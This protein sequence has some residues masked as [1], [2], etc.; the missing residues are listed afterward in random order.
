PQ[1]APTAIIN[2]TIHTVA[3]GTI[4]R[5]YVLF[6][7][8]KIIEVKEG[9]GAFTGITRLID[10]D[11]Q[12][13]YPGL[14][15]AMTQ[16][17]LDEISAVRAMRDHNEVGRLSPEVHAAI[18]VNPDSTL[19]PVAR[20]N[21]ILIAGSWPTGGLVPGRASVLQLEGWTTE[22]MALDPHAGVIINWPLARP[23]VEWWMDQTESDQ[24][25]RINANRARID[26][27]FQSAITY[28]AQDPAARTPDLRLDAL[29]DTLPTAN[30]QKPVFISAQDMDQITTA[31]EW[32]IGLDLK[33]VIV[34]GRDAPMV[35]EL[36]K[37]HDVPVILRGAHGFPKRADSNYDD[38][39]T[40]PARLKNAGVR[41]ALAS[42]EETGHERNLPYN[43]ATAVAYGSD[44]GF[45]HD[46]AIRAVTLSPAEI[47]GVANLVGSIEPGKHATLLITDGSPLEYTTTI[48]QAFIAGRDVDLS[49]KQTELR[50]KYREKYRQ[51]DSNE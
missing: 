22:D 20:T 29:A 51:I 30:P 39:F 38:A 3:N 9:D 14:F 18:S 28:N 31:V 48:S 45:T 15:G 23:R 10:A 32:A 7:E 36:L 19:I 12:H 16:L 49:N 13:V 46:D 33:P 42:G 34:G 44:L 35:A 43:A 50:D 41:F 27:L 47:M 17:G 26:N 25:K 11:G 5:G 6:D 1:Q 24:L 2:A 8:G 40:L 4:D 21:G 37:A